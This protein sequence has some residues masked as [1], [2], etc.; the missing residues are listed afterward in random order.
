MKNRTK[1]TLLLVMAVIAEFAVLIGLIQFQQNI[2]MSFSLP[3]RDMLMIVIQWALL[4]VPE[5][6]MI[7][8]KTHLKDIG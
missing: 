3:I 6:F 7:C 1:N 8:K 2:L 4:V 5:A